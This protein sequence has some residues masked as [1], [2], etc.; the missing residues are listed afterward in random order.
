M[1][2][3]AAAVRG[4][5]GFLTRIPVGRDE[6]AWKAFCGAPVAFP[7]VGYV[8]G[9]LVALPVLLPVPDGTV[10]VAFVA[11]VYLVSG[12][13]HL[14]GVAD[15]GDAAVVHGNRERR[16]AVLKDSDTGV[17]GLLAVALVIVGLAFA[18]LGLAGLPVRAVVAV[19]V[20]AEVGAKAGMALLAAVGHPA[21]DG[22][23]SQLT[24]RTDSR[25]V[26]PVL[27][28]VLPVAVLAWPVAAVGVIVALATAMVLCRWADAA[29]GGVSGDVFGATN[30]VGRVLALHAGVIAWTLW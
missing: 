8:V 26:L 17:G 16:R 21:H 2:L 20:A 9:A 10:A 29:L 15:V 30:E 5:F 18:G 23:G 25:D 6:T 7:L 3:T 13:N 27:I 1:A 24:D 12:I 14:D 22:L 4:A 19:V 11:A 28:V